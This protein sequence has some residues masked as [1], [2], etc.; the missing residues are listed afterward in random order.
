[1]T[2]EL[3]KQLYINYYLSY[4]KYNGV[5][6]FTNPLVC[7]E[8]QTDFIEYIRND[9]DFSKY[10]PVI[11]SSMCYIS[12]LYL[13]PFDVN[14]EHQPVH[15]INE[16]NKVN[17]SSDYSKEP[18]ISTH[19]IE[20]NYPKIYDMISKGKK[21]I[22]C[23][24]YHYHDD[25]YCQENVDFVSFIESRLNKNLGLNTLMMTL[26]LT[27]MAW[28]FG[29]LKSYIPWKIYRPLDACFWCYRLDAYDYEDTKA[30][31]SE[32][33]KN[34][35]DEFACEMRPIMT[36]VK[37]E[38]V[39]VNRPELDGYDA[40]PND[41]LPNVF[42]DIEQYFIDNYYEIIDNKNIEEHYK[43]AVDVVLSNSVKHIV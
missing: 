8:T 3:P 25:Y 15:D 12:Y 38:D 36:Y 26:L 19:E 13:D 20:T 16:L 35:I 18:M 23:W 40:L 28:K 22:I 34:Y 1:M 9:S 39:V 32:Y 14:N 2:F 17:Q 41:T 4:G 37:F 24:C 30:L 21:V 42:T 10:S 43:K 31:A 5:G 29:Q 33:V 7:E 27:K 6:T 11:L